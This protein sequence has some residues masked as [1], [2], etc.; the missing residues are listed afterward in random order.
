MGNQES[1]A[2]SNPNPNENENEKEKE[3]NDTAQPQTQLTTMNI[4]T[5]KPRMAIISASPV[6]GSPLGQSEQISISACFNRTRLSYEKNSILGSSP[7]TRA[8]YAQPAAEKPFANS[9]RIVHGALAPLAPLGPSAAGVVPV[10]IVWPHPGKVV[11]LTGSFNNWKKKI[12][13]QKSSEDFSTIVD[14]PPG[15]HQFKFIVDDEWKCSEDLPVG[16]DSEGNLVNCLQ[17]NDEDGH[18]IRDGLEGLTAE[19]GFEPVEAESPR[20]SYDCIIPL[21]PSL[22]LEETPP[23]LPT[24]LQKV[25]LNSKSIPNQDP[26]LLPMPNHVCVNHLY[27]CSIRDGVMAIA[28]TNRYKKKHITTVLFRRI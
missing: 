5:L 14:M 10:M 11:H 16:S 3:Q 24:H 2:S 7:R 20:S 6:T 15:M 8:E 4:P 12:R 13:L 19:Y 1:K 23:P 22:N 25:L 27:A 28:T 9:A 26:N 17:V 18:S 21:M